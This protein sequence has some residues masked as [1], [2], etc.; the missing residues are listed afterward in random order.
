[1]AVAVLPAAAGLSGQGA[2]DAGTFADGFRT[3]MLIASVLCAAGGVLAA[4]TIR[5]RVHVAA[6]Q[7][8][9]CSGCAV[10]GPALAVR[11]A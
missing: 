11:R 2:L 3:A 9:P 7:G 8:R 1:M 10:E 6:S 4:L 5:N